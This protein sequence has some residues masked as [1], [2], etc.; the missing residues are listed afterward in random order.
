MLGPDGYLL[1]LE[2]YAGVRLYIPKMEST[3]RVY[4]LVDDITFEHAEKLSEAYGGDYI[5]V[6]M[7]RD[8]RAIAYRQKGFSTRKI[9]RSIGITEGGLT[10]LWSRLENEGVELGPAPR[11]GRMGKR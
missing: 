3:G 7:D 8:F 4:Q 9:V 10:K 5:K 2:H 1:L 6:P 11:C